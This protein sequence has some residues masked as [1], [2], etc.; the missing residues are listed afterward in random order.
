[1]IENNHINDQLLHKIE[2]EQHV[3]IPQIIAVLKLIEDGGTV[4][5]IA[6]YRKEVTGGLDEDQI[7]A[8]YQEW[9]YGQKL[10]ERKEDIMRLIDEKGKLTEELRQQIIASDKLSELEDIYRPFKEKKKTRAT[11][12]KR[13]GLEGL[14]NYLLSFPTEG[15]VEKEAQAYVTAEPTEEQI[16]EGLVVKDVKEALQGAEDIIA[17]IVSDEPKYRRWIRRLFATRGELYSTVKDESLDEKHVYAMYYNYKEP[18]NEIKLHRVL[19][20]NRGE[21]EKV[22]KVGILADDERVYK[23]L[24]K[25]VIT[26]PNS[27][28]ASYVKDAIEDAY[29]RLIKSSIERDIRAELK[30]KAEDQAITVF[31]E[32]LKRYLLTPP[33]KGKVVLG[34]DPAYRTG[35]KLA[36]VDATGKVL[37]KG[38]IYPNQ[39]NKEEVVSD[40]RT[41][42][43]FDIIR[44]FIDVY[45]VE[46]IAIG[47]GTAS[48]ET[49]SFIAETIKKLDKEVY[50]IIVNEAGASI[51]SAS[52]IAQE[53]FPDYHVEERSAVSIARRLQDPL[54]ELVK[55]DPKSIGVGQYQY[56]VTQSKLSDALDF[57]V[58]TAVNSVGVNINNASV[59]LLQRVSGLNAKTAKLIV[60]YRNENGEFKNRE[61]L[62]IKGIGPKTLEQAIGFLR[63]PNGTEKLDMTA[64]H[65]ESYKVAEEI[66]AKLGFTK[67]DIGTDALVKAINKLNRK[68]FIKEFEVGEYT[69]NDILDAFVA[70]LRDPRDRFDRPVLRSD[71]LHLEDLVPGM[72]LQGAVRNV[73]DF[74]A[75]VDCGVK[76][77]GLVHTSRMSKQYIKHPLD[78]V[79]V[80]DVVKVWVVSVDLAR[81]RVE[82]T[83]IPPMGK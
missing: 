35:C 49:E 8:I 33:M 10:A 47:N 76:E 19:A 40:A 27:I 38:V 83:M 58:E 23:F 2:V 51:Y 82:L 31:A 62:K 3:T 36:V 30:D 69:F 73:V 11:E 17:E 4:P 22:L 55:I 21:S 41:Q 39:K 28:T 25:Q 70:P 60:D 16:K 48:R 78:V 12:A 37:N 57:V 56:D 64:I 5:F 6:R 65:P 74:G 68:E 80:G 44:T 42:Q 71:V 29:N 77:D 54:S 26:N 66:L 45:N 43:S 15:D 67:D 9:E 34:V 61:E 63:I 32:N 13:R 46:V 59:P 75:F 18:V 20:L 79:S 81:G 53:E 52:K 14:A 1:M 72:E 24:A 7:R 50:Y